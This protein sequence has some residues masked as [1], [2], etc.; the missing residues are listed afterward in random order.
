MFAFG[1]NPSFDFNSSLP[2][3]AE[4]T[5]APGDLP[6]ALRRRRRRAD[7]G[8][9]RPP[10]DGSPID[11]ADLD[12]VPAA[13]SRAPRAW[14]RST[15]AQLSEDG[16][17]AESRSI[18]D[19]DPVSDAALAD[20]KGPIRDAAHDAAPDGT[21]AYVGGTPSVFADL[22][23]AMDRDYSVVFPVAALIIMLILALLLR[24]LVAPLLPDGGGR[25]RLRAPPWA[26][27]SSSSSTSRASPA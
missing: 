9:A 19:D 24:S 11:E 27:P 4:S 10:T 21:E 25:P 1:F 3:D 16:T 2:D 8:H 13:T 5:E 12:R 17:A 20:V 7:P 26:R 23:E 18:L 22:Q 15:P 6:G 14:R